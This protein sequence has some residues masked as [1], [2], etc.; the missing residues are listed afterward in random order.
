MAGKIWRNQCGVYI[1]RSTLLIVF[2]PCKS[3][4][5]VWE[6]DKKTHTESVIRQSDKRA[7][8]MGWTKEE[9]VPRM[10]QDHSLQMLLQVISNSDRP[11][12]TPSPETNLFTPSSLQSLHI[13]WI[14]KMLQGHKPRD[15]LYAPHPI[16]PDVNSH[17][18]NQS[19][20]FGFYFIFTSLPGFLGTVF[21]FLTK[22]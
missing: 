18:L 12:P 5:N 2:P 22:L 16:C 9:N 15:W 11:T 17:N 13:S 20:S 6:T 7:S 1:V 3:K 10:K 8:G 4:A 19:L 14:K 21:I